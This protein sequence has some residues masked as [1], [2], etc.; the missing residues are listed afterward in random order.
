MMMPASTRDSRGGRVGAGA[1]VRSSRP[2]R[3]DWPEGLP[4]LADS[5][6]ATPATPRAVALSSV[7]P[8][9]ADATPIEVAASNLALPGFSA[10]LDRGPSALDPQMSAPE[11]KSHYAD[12]IDPN[13]MDREQPQCRQDIRWRYRRCGRGSDRME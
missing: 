9:P 8:A 11:A 4:P 2:V 3:L 1:S 13:A 10:R 5:D 6:G 7:T 12:L